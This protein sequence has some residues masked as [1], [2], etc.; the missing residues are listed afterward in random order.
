MPVGARRSL[1]L[2]CCP[3]AAASSSGHKPPWLRG[4][5][6]HFAS[7][8]YAFRS[9]TGRFRFSIVQLRCP[10]P[11]GRFGLSANGKKTPLPESPPALVGT[12]TGTCAFLYVQLQRPDSRVITPPG[13]V[14]KCATSPMHLIPVKSKRAALAFLYLQLTEKVRYS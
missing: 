7:A 13:Y 4:K 2:F 10:V 3:A 8:S 9:L 1:S 5:E 12:K 6:R 11:R 14:A